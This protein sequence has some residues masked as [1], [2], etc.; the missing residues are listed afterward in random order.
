[1][2]FDAFATRAAACMS[3]PAEVPAAVVPFIIRVGES[4][5]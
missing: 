2:L 5:N 1:M 4:A 3:S